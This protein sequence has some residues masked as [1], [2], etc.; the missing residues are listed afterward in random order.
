MLIR[1][2]PFLGLGLL[3][4]ILGYQLADIVPM[5][6]RVYLQIVFVGMVF[7][8]IILDKEPGWNLVLLICFGTTAGMMFF[9][10][11][12]NFLQLK[13]WAVFVILFMISLT[14]GVLMKGAGR[15]VGGLLFFCTFLY[16]IGWILFMIIP[17]PDLSGIIWIVLG[18]A[19]FT[20]ILMALISQG[21]T[22][23][24]DS[25]AVPLSIQLFMILFNLCWL[26]CL[27]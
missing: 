18:L 8:M 10:A 23:N 16:L 7:S 24:G 20:F 26:S 2:A 3:V 5:A 21:K 12:S 25:S 13:S 27:L 15:W 22:Q 11:G 14:G 1:V 4:L 19:L 6:A 17:L 9:W